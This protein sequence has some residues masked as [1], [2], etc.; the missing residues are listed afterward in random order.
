MGLLDHVANPD[1]DQLA[2]EY[3]VLENYYVNGKYDFAQLEASYQLADV[4]LRKYF[5][6]HVNLSR[7]HLCPRIA[8]R[9]DYILW[10]KKLVEH[11]TEHEI[12]GLDM[13]TGA[14]CIY[15][16]LGCSV[17]DWMFYGTDI[18]NSSLEL[19]HENIKQNYLS[20]RINVQK[21]GIKLFDL[22]NLGVDDLTFTMCNPPFYDT[23]K[24]MENSKRA[25]ELNPSTIK[26]V[27]QDS[28]L[29]TIG[30]EEALTSQM[31]SESLQLKDRIQWYTTMVGKKSTLERIVPALKQ[32]GTNNYAIHEIIHGYGKTRRWVIAWSFGYWRI[33][34]KYA[35]SNSH[36]IRHLNPTTNEF[37]F[38]SSMEN[39]L[40]KLRSLPVDITSADPVTIVECKGNV[41]SRSYRRK[42]ERGEDVEMN[43]FY[44]FKF[45]KDSI[46]WVYGKDP[47][48]F[49]AF[50]SMIDKVDK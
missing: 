49:E 18:N 2:N 47:K 4:L 28:E 19:C 23:A 43:E 46:Q 7:Q 39:V 30:G 6:L 45:E 27:A 31:V 37:K 40:I 16:L 5:G 41:W 33:K 17:T 22:D 24:E 48:V 38:R 3:P 11:T 13:G 21:G 32:E 12:V 1:I 9:L 50:C 36:S 29:F 35:R 44:R 26:L 25:K 8:N 42:I 10:I 34:D 15:P 14:S 20:H